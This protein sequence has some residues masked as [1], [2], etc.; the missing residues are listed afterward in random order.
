M[1]A[2]VT[3]QTLIYFIHGSIGLIV[4]GLLFDQGKRNIKTKGSNQF[5]GKI[6]ALPFF[7]FVLVFGGILQ[8]IDPIIY[9]VVHS[10]PPL[11]RGGIMIIGTMILLNYSIQ[12]FNYT[13]QK[14]IIVYSFGII[15]LSWPII[16]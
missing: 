13:D 12:Y 1:V 16:Q 2:T 4:G 3:E 14:S 8:F 6:E 11:T 15:I 10:I 5:K 9:S 7:F